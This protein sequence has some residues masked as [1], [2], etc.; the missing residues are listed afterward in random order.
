MPKDEILR[1]MD[2][3]TLGG[4]GERMDTD[5]DQYTHKAGTEPQDLGDGRDDGGALLSESEDEGDR[6]DAPAF[7]MASNTLDANPIT[8]KDWSSRKKLAVVMEVPPNEIK[9]LYEGPH[10]MRIFG[11]LDEGYLQPQKR[12]LQAESKVPT[13]S[14]GANVVIEMAKSSTK[15]DYA[16]ASEEEKARWD[17]AEWHVWYLFQADEAFHGRS[18]GVLYH[19]S[20]SRDVV[21]RLLWGLLQL[22]RKNTVESRVRR[23]KGKRGA[24]DRGGKTLTAAIQ[25]S[26]GIPETPSKPKKGTSG[27]GKDDSRIGSTAARKLR[28]K[29]PLFEPGTNTVTGTQ[30]LRSAQELDG[31]SEGDAPAPDPEASTEARE[32]SRKAQQ[33]EQQRQGVEKLREKCASP[34]AYD[35]TDPY[36]MYLTVCAITAAPGLVEPYTTP[37]D[38]WAEFRKRPSKAAKATWIEKLYRDI[39]SRRLEAGAGNQPSAQLA[40]VRDIVE[41]VAHADSAAVGASE[42][43][44]FDI[45]HDTAAERASFKEMSA[46]L[47]GWLDNKRYQPVN[48]KE[49]CKTLGVANNSYPAIPGAVSGKYLKWWQVTEAS[50]VH[51]LREQGRRGYVLADIMGLGKTVTAATILVDVSLQPP[52]T[53]CSLGSCCG[54]YPQQAPSPLSRPRSGRC[55]N[56]S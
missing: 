28:K 20:K 22:Y 24:S 12:K 14:I 36:W 26:L 2:V 27:G 9:K 15:A 1:M 49:S 23:G 8:E 17:F 18:D 10:W 38:V 6:A 43:T 35:A 3:D 7:E 44:D 41:A 40:D 55:A 11:E 45:V 54:Y 47:S 48:Y 30:Y 52:S 51:K 42:E 4:G 13:R 56:F 32:A 25:S 19:T 37:L 5:N 34:G 53:L 31:D 21:Y 50:K 16:L 46:L 33:E 29:L 39:R